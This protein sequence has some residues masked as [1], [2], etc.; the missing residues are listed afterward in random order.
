MSTS[1]R[2][3]PASRQIRLAATPE[4]AEVVRRIRNAGRTWFG[5][6]HEI[7]RDEQRRWWAT[8]A[9][10]EGF[11]CVL[12]GEPPVGYGML[13]RRGDG[14]RWVAL[15]VDPA[16]RGRGV[17]TEIYRVL[18]GMADDGE[19]IYAGIRRD[20]TPSIAAARRAGYQ[21]DDAVRAPVAD[22][23]HWLVLRGDGWMTTGDR[24][25]RT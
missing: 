13:Q 23:D 25:P 15:A 10:S 17:G 21:P 19:P 18:L 20:N 24:G 9:R 12:V 16:E 11:V 6:D 8:H 22:P 2:D 3:H 4:D 14:R 7:T 5:D 1:K